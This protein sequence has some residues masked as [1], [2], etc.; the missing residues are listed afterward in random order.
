MSMK[1][2]IYLIFLYSME[3]KVLEVGLPK[4]VFYIQIHT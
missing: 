2:V 4:Q 3:E 1:L